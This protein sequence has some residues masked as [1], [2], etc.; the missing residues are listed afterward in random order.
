MIGPMRNTLEGLEANFDS[1]FKSIILLLNHITFSVLPPPFLG[2]CVQTLLR[3]MRIITC[4]LRM[5]VAI[6]G[7]DRVQVVHKMCASGA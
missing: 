3:G 1:L 2:A 6:A 4:K 5:V 7:V